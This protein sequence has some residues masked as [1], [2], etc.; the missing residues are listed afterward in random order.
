MLNKII[1]IQVFAKARFVPD[2]RENIYLY[3]VSTFFESS[4]INT[5]CPHLLGRARVGRS[6]HSERL[7]VISAINEE[8][9]ARDEEAKKRPNFDG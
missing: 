2:S 5:T 3:I 1:A 4:C 7:N 8:E 6:I 9:R